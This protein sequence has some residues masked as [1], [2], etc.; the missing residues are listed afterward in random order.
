MGGGEQ[1]GGKAGKDI[2]TGYIIHK[3]NTTSW[4]VTFCGLTYVIW[5]KYY[6]NFVILIRGKCCLLIFYKGVGRLG[7][8]A[9]VL[10]L[11]LVVQCSIYEY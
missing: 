5:I 4:A 9:Q 1:G 11:I 2:I 3:S 6:Q 8:A 10:L 7:F